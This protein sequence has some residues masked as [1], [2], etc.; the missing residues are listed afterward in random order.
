M[1]HTE[2][3]NCTLGPKILLFG[4]NKDVF[5]CIHNILIDKFLN[6]LVT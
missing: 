1:T 5:L 2:L 4:L 6:K 3:D